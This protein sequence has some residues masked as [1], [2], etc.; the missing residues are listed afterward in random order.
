MGSND[1]KLRPSVAQ[2]SAQWREPSVARELVALGIESPAQIGSLFI[3]DS[4]LLT[5][6]TADVAPV[7]DNHP[8]RISSRQLTTRTFVELYGELMDEGERLERFR[9]SDY[10]NELWPAELKNTS[11]RFFEYE[12]LIRSYFSAGIYRHRADPYVWEAIDDLLTNTSLST[13]PLWLLGSDQDTQ[14]VV[15]K[16]MEKEGYRDEFALELARKHASERDYATAL[17]HV[18]NHITTIDAVPD[19]DMLFYL[20][21]LAKN[22]LLTQAKPIIAELQIHG[23]PRINRFL[24]WFAIKFELQIAESLEHLDLSAQQATEAVIRH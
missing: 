8:A 6:L 5:V 9:K 19:W 17:Q 20:Y 3:A 14:D 7:T 23:L 24:D 18:E 22:G 16:L 15:A 4:D 12:R 13:L 21:L 1:A 2:F 11:E 10:I